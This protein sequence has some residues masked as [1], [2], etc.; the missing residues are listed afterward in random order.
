MRTVAT[1]M[2]VALLTLLLTPMAAAH[3]IAAA[4]ESP[5]TGAR[6][7]LF[8]NFDEAHHEFWIESNGVITGGV[9]G[10]TTAFGLAGERSGLQ[11]TPFEDA[12]GRLVDADTQLTEEQWVAAC[13]A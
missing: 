13:L 6:C 9:D 12:N 7:Y 3:P 8:T 11:R 5:T 1:L 10:P 4:L 2:T